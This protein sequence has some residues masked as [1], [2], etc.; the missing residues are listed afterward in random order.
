MILHIAYTQYPLKRGIQIFGKDGEKAVE[1]EIE[2]LDYMDVPDPKQ[3]S[4]LTEQDQRRAL[5]YL[6]FLKKKRSGKIK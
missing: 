3:P 5:G 4:E 2:Q 6:M 1:T